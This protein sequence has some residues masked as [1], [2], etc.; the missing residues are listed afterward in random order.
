VTEIEETWPFERI[1]K[2]LAYLEMT[3]DIEKQIHKIMM[4]KEKP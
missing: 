4:P 2:G 3:S 1:R